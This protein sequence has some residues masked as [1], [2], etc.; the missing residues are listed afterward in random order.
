MS[1]SK[2]SAPLVGLFLVPSSGIAGVFE[3]V[4]HSE[5]CLRYTIQITDGVASIVPLVVG[6]GQV[7]ERVYND[8]TVDLQPGHLIKAIRCCGLWLPFT[9]DC[10]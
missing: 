3:N 5:E 10:G 7:V 2:T 1:K 4:V 6:D 9:E 8:M